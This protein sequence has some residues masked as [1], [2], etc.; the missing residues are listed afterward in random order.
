MTIKAILFDLDGVLVDATEWHYRALNR[1]LHP[2]GYEI[3]RP[4]HLSTYNGLPTSRK[5]EILTASKGLPRELH[6][7]VRRLKQEYT[8]E[9]IA[10]LCVP[11]GDKQEL[12]RRLR[13]DGYRLAVCSNSIRESVELILLRS[14]LGEFFELTLSNEDVLNSKPHPEMHRLACR[15]LG[16]AMGEALV[17]EDAPQGIEAV[18]RLGAHICLVGGVEE[19]N[20]ARIQ[21]AL[22]DARGAAH[23]STPAGLG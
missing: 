3:P 9:E 12:L 19:V 2:L 11:V 4:E 17:V 7:Q 8:R 23:Q 13:D 1:A 6:A 18:R 22:A 16:V 20:Y 21:R 14:G 15:R 10:R 5:L